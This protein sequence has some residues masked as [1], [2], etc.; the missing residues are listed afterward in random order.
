LLAVDNFGRRNRIGSTVQID[1][2]TQGVPVAHIEFHPHAA[3]KWGHAARSAGH[4]V[5]GAKKKVVTAEKDVGSAHVSGTALSGASHRYI[6]GIESAIASVAGALTG[7]GD[8]L[9]TTVAVITS[10]DDR[11]S[12]LFKAPV[13]LYANKPHWYG[14]GGGVAP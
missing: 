6:S 3:R 1:R 2:K 7:T 12:D 4:G 5:R 8:Q 9:L 14:V 10:A 13:G 11:S